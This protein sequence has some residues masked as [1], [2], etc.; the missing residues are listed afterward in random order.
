MHPHVCEALASA[1]E[2]KGTSGCNAPNATGTLTSPPPPASSPPPDLSLPRLLAK[3][4]I[5]G[6]GG[7]TGGPNLG[8]EMVNSSTWPLWGLGVWS[9][10]GQGPSVLGTLA[11][12][13]HGKPVMQQIYMPLPS[14]ALTCSPNEPRVL[15]GLQ[16]ELD[17][18]SPHRA[19]PITVNHHTW[20]PTTAPPAGLCHHGIP[21]MRP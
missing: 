11:Q 4:T 14:W 5:E 20:L 2:R 21:Q 18:V 12:R 3:V 19:S 9:A 7:G 16:K 15:R 8:R 6:G 17:A 13:G 1:E 10:G